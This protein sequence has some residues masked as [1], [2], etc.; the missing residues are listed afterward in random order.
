MKELTITVKDFAE[1][2]ADADKMVALREIDE[3]GRETGRK[4]V[5]KVVSASMYIG[6]KEVKGKEVKKADDGLMIRPGYYNP[7]SAY[8][9]R[10]VIKA[11]GLDWNLGTA[12]KYIERRGNKQGET[13]LKD[14]K[15]ALTYIHFAVE[16][17]EERLASEKGD[18]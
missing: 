1:L 10:K 14:L 7:D 5:C 15:K 12:L 17:E 4:V 8:E 2:F 13:T 16:D 18:K 9:P 6:G 11:W 3:H